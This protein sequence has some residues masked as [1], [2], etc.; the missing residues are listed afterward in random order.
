VRRSLELPDGRGVFLGLEP[1]RYELR[2]EAAGRLAAWKQ[3]T[4]RNR[5]LAELEV[6]VDDSRT[7]SVPRR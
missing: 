2:I 3:L 7:E 6:P 5:V 1:G 4:F